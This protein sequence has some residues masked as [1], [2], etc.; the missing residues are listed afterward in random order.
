V[1][2]VL[3]FDSRF[4]GKFEKIGQLQAEPNFILRIPIVPLPAGDKILKQGKDTILNE[5][6]NHWRHSH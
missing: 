5:A 6:I 1:P 3:K 4:A 2:S